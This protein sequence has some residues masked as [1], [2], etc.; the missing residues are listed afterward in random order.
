MTPR[1]ERFERRTSPSG[2][3]YFWPVW[4]QLE[5]DR[6]G[7]DVWALVRGYITLTPLALDASGGAADLT[8]LRGFERDA[9]SVAIP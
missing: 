2:R 8:S 7:T 9:A 1:P 6:E 5:E 4:E 3:I